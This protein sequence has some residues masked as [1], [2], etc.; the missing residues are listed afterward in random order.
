MSVLLGGTEVLKKAVYIWETPIRIYHWLNVVLIVILLITGLYIGKP[1]L[2]TPGEPYANFLMGKIRIWHALAAWVFIANFI[3]RFYWAF[4]G[5]KYAKFTLWSKDLLTDALET[6]K[7]YL[8]LKKEHT[9]H[10]GHNVI[11]QMAYFLVMWVG[12]VFM[13][14]TGL[15][16]QGEIAPGGLQ[17]RWLGWLIPLF[18]QS[19][20]VRIYHHLTAWLFIAFIVVHLYLVIRQELLDDDGTVSSI[21]S[22]YKFV[23]TDVE[24]THDE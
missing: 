11:A 18:G 3:F 12:S 21:I 14:I 6:L 7:Y 19:S 5:N 20:S 23:I 4:V 8:F 22:G 1:V 16:M 24:E 13:I 15:A 17:E 2:T 9:L 10:T